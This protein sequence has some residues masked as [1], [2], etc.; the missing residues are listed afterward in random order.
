VQLTAQDLNWLLEYGGIKPDQ[1]F[2]AWIR[3]RY[4]MPDEDPNDPIYQRPTRRTT[5]RRRQEAPSA[6]ELPT[7]PLPRQRQAAPRCH[8]PSPRTAT[9][10][11]QRR[12]GEGTARRHARHLRRHRHWGGWW[13]ISARDVDAAL[14][15]IGDVDTLYV[16]LN[17]PGGEATEGVAIANL[18]RAHKADVRVTVY[19]SPPR[20]RRTSHRRRHVVSMAPGSLMMVHD[21]WN[22][23]FGTADDMRARGR[24]A[25][26]DLRQHRQPVRAQGRRHRRAVARPR[27]A[28]TP[29][30]PPRQ[31]VAAKLADAGRARPADCRPTCRPSRRTT[32]RTTTPPSS[33]S[34]SRSARPPAPPPAASTCRCSPTRPPRWRRP[35]TPAE[36]PV[37][38]PTET[39]EADAMSDTENKGLRERLGLAE[40]ADEATVLA[41]VDELLDQATKP[42]PAQAEAAAAEIPDGKVLVSQT[43]STS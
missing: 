26:H 40:D 10:P 41:K 34:T 15:Q 27:C 16:R 23:A 17:S 1:P 28:P 3:Q 4:G 20:P 36:P 29:G 9:R 31:A 37:T 13:G 33:R 32:T 24:R 14:K 7:L 2:R 39:K 6:D 8:A 5:A 25:R 43:S 11:R 30:T 21:A 22:I 42:D 35:Q 18:L 12:R 38:P 19:G